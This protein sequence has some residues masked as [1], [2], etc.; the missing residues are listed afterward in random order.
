VEV[1]LA[2]W[3]WRGKMEELKKGD[4]PTK[5]D[6]VK[7]PTGHLARVNWSSE[8][9]D[10][11]VTYLPQSPYSGLESM[12]FRIDEVEMV[13][14]G[15]QSFFR[16]VFEKMSDEEL[17]EELRKE[18]AVRASSP[19]PSQEK[20]RKESEVGKLL[21]QLSPEETEKLKEWIKKRKE[22]ER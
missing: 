18:R 12:V 6:I 8:R 2:K 15:E 22:E 13:K 7:T 5:G 14:R 11:G 17:R 21:K 16:E 10:C 3:K 9:G 4:I 19:S 1:E 20:E